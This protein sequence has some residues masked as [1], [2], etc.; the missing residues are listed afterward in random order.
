M[1]KILRVFFRIIIVIS[2][3]ALTIIIT[4][5]IS[6]NKNIPD[7][8]S[9]IIL[10]VLMSITII[11]GVFLLSNP[12]VKI[13]FKKRTKIKKGDKSKEFTQICDNLTGECETIN[14]Y[15]KRAI[16][17][18]L[19]III[20]CEFAF[21]ISLYSQKFSIIALFIIL[22]LVV[23]VV[24]LYKKNLKEFN[25]E[26]KKTIMPKIVYYICPNLQYYFDGDDNMFKT[27]RSV[28]PENEEYNG[29]E[30]SDYIY[31]NMNG[32]SLQI[33]KI[34]LLNYYSD[35]SDDELNTFE[36]FLFSQNKINF[37][38]PSTITIKSNNYFN[39]YKTGRVQMDSEEFEKYFDIFSDSDMIAVQILTH[40]VM[41]ELV[42]FYTK[43]RCKFELIIKENNLFIKFLTGDVFNPKVFKKVT[44]S[45]LLWTY[46]T[47]LNF[48][49]RL[50]IKI[51]KSLDG[52]EI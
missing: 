17:Y 51:N 1:K 30:I 18:I 33:C 29:Y 5:K 34:S 48:V 3:I 26:F 12:T 20:G 45:D 32:V 43:Y 40:D 9:T 36:T 52:T 49:T 50:C 44:D 19:L 28:F 14:E 25:Y 47:I 23:S 10:I 4:N 41:E 24:S 13:S 46:Y 21:L 22:A 6:E 38:V 8:L 37:S 27:Y 15:R 39:T 11:S 16:I 35:R 42:S 7:S 31:G 2:M